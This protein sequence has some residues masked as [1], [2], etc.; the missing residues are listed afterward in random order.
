MDRV[1]RDYD[2]ARIVAG[3]RARVSGRD[4]QVR[5]TREYG[6]VVFVVSHVP[7]EGFRYGR[8]AEGEIVR[9]SDPL[10]VI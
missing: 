9:P 10:I 8:D 5:R 3:I 2:K 7:G 4:V 6:R 1:F